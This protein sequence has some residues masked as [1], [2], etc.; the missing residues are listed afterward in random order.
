MDLTPEIEER[1]ARLQEKY[2][3][4]QERIR[5]LAS[6]TKNLD[7]GIDLVKAAATGYELLTGVTALFGKENAAAEETVKKL[8]A[9][10]AILNGVEELQ[11]L[12]R[13]QSVI[14]IVGEEAAVAQLGQH[15]MLAEKLEIRLGFFARSD[16]GERDEHEVP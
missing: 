12:L 9:I 14:S 11:R 3:R 7:F 10:M 6:Q 2:E 15:V 1:L 13:K 8:V 4:V 5:I 16:V